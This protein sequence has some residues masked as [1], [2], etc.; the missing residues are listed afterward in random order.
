MSDVLIGRNSPKRILVDLLTERWKDLHVL[1]LFCF[2]F[3]KISLFNVFI[4]FKTLKKLNISKKFE[5]NLPKSQNIT[6][7]LSLPFVF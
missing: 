6:Y 2:F 7:L 3:L 4:C 1:S 5:N